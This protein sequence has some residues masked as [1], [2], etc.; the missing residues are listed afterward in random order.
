[1]LACLIPGALR[2][3][4]SSWK[5][6]FAGRP[7]PTETGWSQSVTEPTAIWK[8]KILWM[9]I[10]SRNMAQLCQLLFLFF[11]FPSLAQ[12]EVLQFCVFS[13]SKV[14][15]RIRSQEQCHSGAPEPCEIFH[16]ASSRGREL[17]V[18][19]LG[20]G[21]KMVIE[22]QQF[23]WIWWIQTGLTTSLSIL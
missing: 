15:E 22:Y 19:Q 4:L 18:A 17:Q 3:C 13:K 11:F 16:W 7:V 1:M 9:F 21:S 5:L 6:G 20:Y 12:L 10:F 2:F 23:M 8:V 14:N